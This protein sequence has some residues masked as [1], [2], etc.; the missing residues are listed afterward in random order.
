MKFSDDLVEVA[1][2]ALGEIVWWSIFYFL[3]WHLAVAGGILVGGDEFFGLSAVPFA[4]LWMLIGWLFEP[5]VLLPLISFF[6]LWAA[7]LY[8]ES[9]L[10]RLLLCALS[11]CI[12]G[13]SVAVIVS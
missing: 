3:M 6:V 5:L 4:L 13:M 11:C 9:V 8:S 12:A 7:S 1:V 10:V 2:S